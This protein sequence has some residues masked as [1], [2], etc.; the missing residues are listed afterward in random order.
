MLL[1]TED[2]GCV[3]WRK[4]QRTNEFRPL[5]SM[6]MFGSYNITHC[7]WCGERLAFVRH[8]SMTVEDVKPPWTDEEAPIP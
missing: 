5:G 4:H 2:R 6:W 3:V 7:P 1:H 8:P